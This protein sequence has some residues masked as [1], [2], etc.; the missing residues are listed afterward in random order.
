MMCSHS[1][2]RA[3][4]S[5]DMTRVLVTGAT[6]FVGG[7]LCE[8]LARSGYTV[9]AAVRTDRGLPPGAAEKVVTEDLGPDTNWQA[10]L[11]DVDVV[12]HAA[13]RTHVLRDAAANARLYRQV[14]AQ[15]TERLAQMAA[16]ARV[17]RF[18]YLSS[19]KVNG[20]QTYGRAFRATDEPE[21]GDAYARSKLQAEAALRQVGAASDLQFAIV[22]PPLVY[23]P[24]VRANFL[25]LM[26][27]V[28]K[29]RPLP[30]AAVANQRSL[31]SLWN[32]LDLI[33]VLM[34]HPAASG[35][36]WL[37]SDGE[38]LSTPELI[39]RL[40]RALQR[41]AWLLPVPPR[42]LLLGGAL[43]GKKSELARLCGSLTLDVTPTRELLQWTAPLTVDEALRRTAA[44]YRSAAL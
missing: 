2:R 1:R 21:P 26:R 28:D 12:V 43:T 22:R 9:R 25:Q 33:D 23:G 27:W 7:A 37:V 11:T 6:G 42:A 38:D 31:V 19:V 13:A 18:V 24:G 35:R 30:F 8:R 29:Q 34:T 17:R 4:A 14:N 10:A 41:K 20:E 39:M 36:V 15:G 32:L 44:W 40:A 5:L 16:Q 3:P